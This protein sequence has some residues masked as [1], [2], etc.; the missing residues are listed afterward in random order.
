MVT[1]LVN[2]MPAS[3]RGS[4]RG[5]C[6]FDGLGAGPLSRR[7]EVEQMYG[8]ALVH[9]AERVDRRP[10]EVLVQATVN[11]LR[12]RPRHGSIAVRRRRQNPR[13][14]AEQ[15]RLGQCR[16]ADIHRSADEH[17]DA[18]HVAGAGVANGDLPPFGRAH[19]HA[20]Q[21]AYDDE[22]PGI[23]VRTVNARASRNLDAL[24]GRQQLVN[25]A[26]RQATQE[27]VP[28]PTHCRPIRPVPRFVTKPACA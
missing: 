9:R 26:V 5:V 17:R 22:R 11:L 21:A 28:T 20:E 12:Q 8:D 24:P 15:A 7:G 25:E 1:V 13:V 19:V 27:A 6:D 18:E 14:D 16:D 4:R 2:F 23:V 3:L 10:P